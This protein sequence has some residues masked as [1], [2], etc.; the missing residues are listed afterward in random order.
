MQNFS[1]G[2]PDGLLHHF[3]SQLTLNDFNMDEIA[4]TMRF[5]K[6]VI[7]IFLDPTLSKIVRTRFL[8][9]FFYLNK[10]F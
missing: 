1:S 9:C 7:T 3:L 10:T 5:C 4:P 6:F 2:N 8:Q